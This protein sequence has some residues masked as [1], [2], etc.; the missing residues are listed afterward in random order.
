MRPWRSTTATGKHSSELVHHGWHFG[1]G[2][3]IR[4]APPSFSSRQTQGIV[5]GLYKVGY[6]HEN[7]RGCPVLA[8]RKA[9]ATP[10]PLANRSFVHG[11]GCEGAVDE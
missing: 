8:T 10:G 3:M 6:A 5:R 4:N 11:D 2:G 7:G 1:G 9:P